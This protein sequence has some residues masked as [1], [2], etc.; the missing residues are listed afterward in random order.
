MSKQGDEIILQNN[1]IDIKI[2]A[3]AKVKL[4]LCFVLD[5]LN[6]GNFN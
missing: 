1:E 5:I 2:K 4:C 3:G 6:L